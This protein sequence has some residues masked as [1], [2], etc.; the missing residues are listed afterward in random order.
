MNEPA[1]KADNQSEKKVIELQSLLAAR[2]QELE[3]ITSEQE[4]AARLLIRRDLALS[5]ANE[6]LLALDVEKSEFIS[7]AA[8][9]L[10]TPLTAIKWILNM[11]LSNEF[12][13]QEESVQFL[14]KASQSTNRMIALVNDLLEVD[15]IQ[16]GK[17]Q[18][19]FVE[20]NVVELIT[21]IVSELQPLA[22][23]RNITLS[24]DMS[25][26][27]LI[28]GDIDKLRSLFQN[29]IE[30]AI[31]YTLE[32]GIV[33]IS[34]SESGL[35]TKPAGTSDVKPEIKIVVED[36]GIG[37]PNEYKDRIFSKFF[38]T[39]NAMKTATIGTGLGLFIAK[40]VVDRHGGMIWFESKPEKGTS[41]FI[42][43]PATF[44]VAVTPVPPIHN[45]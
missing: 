32:K 33:R 34:A 4:D 45:A 23:Q 26:T 42:V 16:S 1:N 13:S 43:L 36:S 35:E 19:V 29:V 3:K 24:V 12:G 18:F 8:H 6:K 37:I 22:K 20:V 27:H 40:Q 17:D 14:Q 44:V 21:S 2:T 15:H 11:A 41:F 28:K 30:N 31:K 38:R 25:V 7:I 5:R 39:P 9:Q 10:R